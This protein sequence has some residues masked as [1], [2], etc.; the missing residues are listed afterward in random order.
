[1]TKIVGGDY[2][3]FLNDK[4]QEFLVL[5]IHHNKIL[6]QEKNRHDA[7]HIQ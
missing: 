6:I 2:I 3:F 1:M 5:S 7:T 4:G